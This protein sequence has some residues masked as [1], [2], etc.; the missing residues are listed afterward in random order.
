MRIGLSLTLAFGAI[1]ISS[2]GTP[3]GLPEAP[4]CPAGDP[5][6][7]SGAQLGA[8][9]YIHAVDRALDALQAVDQ[10]F[11]RDWP[12]RSL[13]TTNSFRRD[14]VAFEGGTRC[15]IEN[16]RRP[17]VPSEVA[18]VSAD[19]LAFL[20]NVEASLDVA[21]EAVDTRN[22]SN[23]SGWIHDFDQLAI[24]YTEY[25]DRLAAAE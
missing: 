19:L 11:R 15:L 24:G 8:G 22:K 18:P 23:Y 7:V 3:A 2:C 21:H 14:F 5:A 20:G 25:Q 12:D 16:I 10:E 9:P 13:H 17:N 6:L 1:L 4:S